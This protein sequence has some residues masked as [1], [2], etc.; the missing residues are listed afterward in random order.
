MELFVTISRTLPNS[1]SE[2][3]S[4]LSLSLVQIFDGYLVPLPAFIKMDRLSPSHLVNLV[5]Y[6][7]HGKSL[8]DFQMVNYLVPN[9]RRLRIIIR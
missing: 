8:V 2:T 1:P 3:V 7:C 6:R 4:R 5:Y 9:A